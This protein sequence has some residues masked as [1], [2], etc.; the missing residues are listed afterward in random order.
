MLAEIL[1]ED[2]DAL[3]LLDG[4]LLAA[5]DWAKADGPRRLDFLVHRGSRLVDAQALGLRGV[6]WAREIAS[7][8]PYLEACH[9]R[10]DVEK[11][12]KLRLRVIV[13][14]LLT[15]IGGGGLAVMNINKIRLASYWLFHTRP[16]VKSKAQEEALIE[17][18]SPFTECRDCPEMVFVRGG[19]FHRGGPLIGSPDANRESPIMEV[20]IQKAFAVSVTEITFAQWDICADQG[21]CRANVLAGEWGRMN[22][23]V[24]HISWGDAQAY[25]RWISKLTGRRYRLLSEV[26][27]EYAARGGKATSYSFEDR[28]INQYA[29][30]AG[31]SEGRPHQVGTLKPNPFGLKDMHGNVAEW[32]EDCFHENYKDAPLTEVAWTEGAFCNRRVVRG[33]NWLSDV[34]ALRSA[35]R[36]WH[37]IDDDI[38]D[39][40]GFRVARNITE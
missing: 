5:A 15:V 7:A 14:L 17:N 31:N 34:K 30:H 33:G 13:A 25:V 20:K 22:Q 10:E 40:I 12:S 9:A 18:H 37:P 19:V 4:V 11:W 35:S 23:P 39:Q 2:R 6:N 16:Y 26:E 38:S 21:G 24:I 1:G 32:V 8:Q 29:W 3:L 27:W 28:N 36:D